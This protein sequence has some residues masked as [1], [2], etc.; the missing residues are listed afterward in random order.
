MTTKI[1]LDCIL[2]AA[3]SRC[4]TFIQFATFMRRVLEVEG[5]SDVFFYCILPDWD[6]PEDELAWLPDHPN[7][8]YLRMPQ[9]KDRTKEYVTFRDEVHDAVLFYGTHWD[10]DIIVTVRSGLAALY[11]ML[12]VSPRQGAFTFTKEIWAIEEMPLMTF[13]TSVLKLNGPVQDRFTLDGYMAADRVM[14][15]SYHEKGEAL[16]IAR[17]YYAPS[18][19]RELEAKIKEVVPVQFKDFHKK[20]EEHFFVPGSGQQFCIAYAGRLMSTGSNIDKI[21]S[22]MTNQWIIRG[23][24]KVRMMVLTN[25]TGGRK[26]VQ[27]PDHIEK[28]YAPR[29]EFWRI[30][31]EEMH[32]LMIMHE[33]AGFLLSMIEP[34]LLGTPA[35]V[36]KEK[37]SLGQLGP[38]YPFYVD[39]EMEAY[40]LL[41]L[42]YEDYAAMYAR[43]VEWYDSWFGPVYKRRFEEDLLYN[44]LLGYLDDFNARL[45]PTYREKGA[46]KV[47]NEIVKLLN[48][49]PADE[50]VLFERIEELGGE[51]LLASL[52]DKTNDHDREVRG[53]IW[54][55]PWNDF[56]LALKAFFGWEDASVK[57]GH[58]RRV[59]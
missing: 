15:M 59:K 32:V 29:E 23:G 10:Y 4:S 21:Y 1:L 5:R 28:F 25:S 57:V 51:G 18:V 12:A 7:I 37:W 36:G 52:S 6:F 8:S 40:T 33:E 34:I 49:T 22:A 41:K 55:S 46:S 39:N 35:I 44:V 16:K 26:K 54:A 48:D 24:D 2:T 42:F 43:F 19:I 13:K 3:P 53:L 14:I 17:G 38:K 31:R 47:D 20:S 27:P 56:R 45:L 58:M 11:K 9:H 30:A 50:M